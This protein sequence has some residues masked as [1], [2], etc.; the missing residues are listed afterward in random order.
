MTPRVSCYQLVTHHVVLLLYCVFDEE[1][2]ICQEDNGCDD[3]P[4]A[5]LLKQSRFGTSEIAHKECGHVVIF[6]DFTHMLLVF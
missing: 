2:D 5:Q 6:G 4:T 3:Q 1:V